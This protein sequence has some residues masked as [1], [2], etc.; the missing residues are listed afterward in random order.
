MIDAGDYNKKISIYQIEEVEDN[1]GFVSKQESII[2]EPFAKVKTTKG[3][4]LISSGSDFEKAYTNFTIRYSKKVEDTYY[5]SNRKM[6]VKYK[7]KTFTI[8]Y[9]NN[10][11]EANIELEIQCKR[12]TK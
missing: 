11:D 6:Y 4:T 8:E 1:D 3:Y 5:N 7:N 12:V 2:L 9:L 10:V